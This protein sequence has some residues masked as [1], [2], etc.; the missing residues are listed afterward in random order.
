M[1]EYIIRLQKLYIEAQVNG[2]P[3]IAAATALLLRQA[4]GR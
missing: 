3:N 1:S 4:L 2:C